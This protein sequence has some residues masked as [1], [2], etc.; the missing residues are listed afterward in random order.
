M[1]HGTTVQVI[2]GK[3][4]NFID[5]R[6]KERCVK[7]TIIKSETYYR[8]IGYSEWNIDYEE[9]IDDPEFLVYI[10]SDDTH[11]GCF[12]DCGGKSVTHNLEPNNE[13]GYA[14]VFR[15]NYY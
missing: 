14:M 8:I 12:R 9:S 2:D 6:P 1:R 13:N 4:S 15:R 11:P 10:P 3:L 7:V 5:H